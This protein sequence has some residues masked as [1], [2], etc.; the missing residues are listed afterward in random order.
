MGNLKSNAPVYRDVNVVVSE[1]LDR[2]LEDVF[3]V[4]GRAV[5]NAV[6]D[7]VYKAVYVDVN[8]GVGGVVDLA[9]WRAVDRAMYEDSDPPAFQDFLIS[10]GAVGCPDV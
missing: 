1:S 8:L 5:D 3:W 9:V 10:C 4:V 6:S 7:D 2:V